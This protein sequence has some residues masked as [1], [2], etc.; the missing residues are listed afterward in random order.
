MLN[1]AIYLIARY[2]FFVNRPSCYCNEWYEHNS[3][4][5]QL[6]RVACLYQKSYYSAGLLTTLGHTKSNMR[7]TFILFDLC[8][9]D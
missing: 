3:C 2:N 8:L 4:N 9:T 7:T 5:E 1:D 6:P